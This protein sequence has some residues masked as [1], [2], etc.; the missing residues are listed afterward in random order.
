M[1]S[2]Y[3]WCLLWKLLFN[4]LKIFEIVML[5]WIWGTE[6]LDQ[7]T[8]GQEILL[9]ELIKIGDVGSSVPSI[10]DMT[11]V[12]NLSEHILEIGIWDNLELLEIVSQHISALV[13]ITLIEFISDRESLSTELS[14][15]ENQ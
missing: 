10:G 3:L 13:Q 7:I 9:D 4:D 15:T 11:T 14:S 12:H 2:K 1:E 5:L 6:W 8:V